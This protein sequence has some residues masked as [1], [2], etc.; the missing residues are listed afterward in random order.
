MLV[1]V[2][3][4]PYNQSLVPISRYELQCRVAGSGEEGEVKNVTAEEE[5]LSETGRFQIFFSVSEAADN[6][7][8]RGRGRG[9]RERT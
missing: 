3:W 8:V 7:E 4:Y 9:G 1:V 2:E 6:Y 5:G